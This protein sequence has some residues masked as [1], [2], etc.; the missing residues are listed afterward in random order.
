MEWRN[1]IV[2]NPSIHNGKP[3]IKG[4]KVTVEQ[5]LEYLSQENTLA[6]LLENFPHVRPN[7]LLAV[8]SY[9]QECVKDGEVKKG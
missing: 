8:F 1:H 6:D 4:T 7:D 5:L 2:S 9:L 3:I